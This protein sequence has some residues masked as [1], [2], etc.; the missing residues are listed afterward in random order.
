MGRRAGQGAEPRSLR[1]RRAGLE[2]FSA[3]PAG[4]R[5]SG[6]PSAGWAPSAQRARSRWDSA[7]HRQRSLVP[8]ATAV[9]N[10]PRTPSWN[11]S[12][13]LYSFTFWSS[14]VAL[15]SPNSH[16]PVASLPALRLC[17]PACQGFK[18]IATTPLLCSVK[19]KTAF[20]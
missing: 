16:K 5:A 9:R 15:R 11:S 7:G 17:Q 2:G 6:E 12:R 10:N 1:L 13:F 20:P 4:L 8:G 18:S 14:G 19:C 3:G